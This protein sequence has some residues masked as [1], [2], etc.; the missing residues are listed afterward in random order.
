MG[1]ARLLPGGVALLGGMAIRVHTSGRW[2][3]LASRTAAAPRVN[4]ALCA[5]A[6]SQQKSHRQALTPS[7]RAL[8]RF[9]SEE[10]AKGGARSINS[11]FVSRCKSLRFIR[12]LFQSEPEPQAPP[13]QRA[14]LGNCT[15]SVSG[16]MRRSRRSVFACVAEFRDRCAVPIVL[17][18]RRNA[19]VERV[20][21]PTLRRRSSQGASWRFGQD[22]VHNESFWFFET[23][24]LR[25]KI[26]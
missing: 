8:A 9:Q 4:A 23:F 12:I 19:E 6:S 16:A 1:E 26:G 22:D 10:V 14:R 15:G 25:S 11:S 13:A 3:P 21:S 18:S 17:V 5:T 20:G 2:P 7:M 24:V